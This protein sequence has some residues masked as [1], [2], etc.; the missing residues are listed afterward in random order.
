MVRTTNALDFTYWTLE[1]HS[2]YRQHYMAIKR[3]D[4]KHNDIQPNETQHKG[5]I[6]DT[7][8]NSHTK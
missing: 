1:L 5:L 8:H 3:H 4:T 2:T 6:C 7:Q